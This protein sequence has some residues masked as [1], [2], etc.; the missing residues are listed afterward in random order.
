MPSPPLAAN[1]QHH[2]GHC[3][4]LRCCRIPGSAW[5]ADVSAC[6]L[7]DGRSRTPHQPPPRRDDPRSGLQPH[8][9]LHPLSNQ[10]RLPKTLCP[11]SAREPKPWASNSIS[12]YFPIAGVIARAPTVKQMEQKK[13]PLLCS[14]IHYHP[15]FTQNG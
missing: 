6:W 15:A 12:S 2:F 13:I 7:H 5:L 3:C 9:P 10:P 4:R 14:R 1:E 11:S 8:Q